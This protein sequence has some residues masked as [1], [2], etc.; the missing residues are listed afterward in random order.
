[1]RQKKIEL[2][3]VKRNNRR[4]ITEK[5]D[6]KRPL[7]TTHLLGRD[8][9]PLKKIIFLECLFTSHSL[10][11]FSAHQKMDYYTIS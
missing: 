10:V 9:M 3:P 1:M 8:D 2:I 6:F 4:D 11:N 5:H 7:S